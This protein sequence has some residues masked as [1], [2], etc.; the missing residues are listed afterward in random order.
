MPTTGNEVSLYFH[1]PFCTRKCPYC[2]FYVTPDKQSSKDLLLQALKQEWN[3]QKEKVKDKKV[4]SIY[5]GGGTPALFGPGPIQTILSWIRVSPDCEI[6]LE[7]NPEEITL[8]LMQAYKA[9]GINR[10][11]IGVQS[12]DDN[13]LKI[14]GR[15]HSAEKALQGIKATYEAGLTN[16]SID[17]MYEIPYQTLPVWQAT[18]DLL[19]DLPI[20]HL[21]LYNLTIEPQTL[22]FKK[23]K[24]LS[25]HL[26]SPDT[27]LEMLNAAVEAFE[28]IGLKRYE[29]SAFSQS[30]YESC[31]NTG[32]WK[33]RPFLGFGPSAF[34]Y[35]E[36]KRFRN[37]AN[38]QK[39]A[40]KL[41]ETLSPIDFEET[42]SPTAQKREL[43]AIALRRLEG[44]S[45]Q[46][47]PVDSSL[48]QE[49]LSK[50]WISIEKKRAKLTP[51]GLLFY[52][53]VGET[54]VEV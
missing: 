54:L 20:K 11:S 41:K 43:L 24:Q 21:S 49:L 3:L 31:H 6:T 1:I 45:I 4:V 28:T 26:P 22:F 12:L 2:H 47:Y 33:G 16:I 10:V 9:S 25:P 29:I 40:Q 52:D 15:T 36:G 19:A 8:E 14:L 35:W 48:Y 46:D 42:L 23:S 17:L 5:F 18:L 7:A 44:V 53:L 13:L 50:G 38:L 32:Y 34:S 51:E 30:G 39:Y 37:I 27:C